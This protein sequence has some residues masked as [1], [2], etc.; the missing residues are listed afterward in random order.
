MHADDDYRACL[1]QPCVHLRKARQETIQ[2]ASVKLVRNRARGV[3][4]RWVCSSVQRC[5][6]V[7]YDLPG[8]SYL[9]NSRH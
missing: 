3:A 9:V 6:E 7:P 8:G 1:S 2:N 4:A 5:G